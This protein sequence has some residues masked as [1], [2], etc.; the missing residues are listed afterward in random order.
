MLQ[1]SMYQSYISFYTSLVQGRVSGEYEEGIP[2]ILNA[3]P[4]TQFL[5]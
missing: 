3:N 4:K 2:V 1:V 5:R